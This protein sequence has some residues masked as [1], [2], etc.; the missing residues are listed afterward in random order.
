MAVS[1][2]RVIVLD[3]APKAVSLSWDEDSLTAPLESAFYIDKQHRGPNPL[4][5][6][7]SRPAWRSVDVGTVAAAIHCGRAGSEDSSR[8]AAKGH[9]AAC[10][11]DAGQSMD[12]G[13][14]IGMS[15]E[16]SVLN[17][18]YERSFAVHEDS[19]T[20]VSISSQGSDATW[21]SSKAEQ[22]FASTQDSRAVP[23]APHLATLKA[24]PSA[25]YIR[26][27]EPQTMTIDLV[28]GVIAIANPRSI[29]TR[30]LKCQMEIV[31]TIVGD[32]TQAPFRISI[33][34][35]AAA[36]SGGE[37]DDLSYIT[38][39]LRPHDVILAK[40]IGLHVFNDQVN[41]QSLRRGL[42]SLQV[43]YRNSVIRAAPKTC[44]S[45][46]DLEAEATHDVCL[47]RTKAVR[48][49]LV[50]NVAMN[51]RPKTTRPRTRAQHA[52]YAADT[53]PPDTQ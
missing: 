8:S 49:W 53:L 15:Q 25:S 3:G 5:A 29:T 16:P 48:D 52:K 34:L 1:A 51:A 26:S 9:N 39:N 40:N 21:S 17:E 14:S 22:S 24:V 35:P 28:L 44:Y 6:A 30:K 12:V 38:K 37:T 20:F 41:G 18:F 43:L 13:S 23:S 19:A 27:I 7:L 33:W 47:Q 50:D 46:K 31:D 11:P 36:R 32:E 4:P 45:A 42:T 10:Y 2:R